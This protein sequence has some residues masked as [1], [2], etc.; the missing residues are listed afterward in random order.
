[1]SISSKNR[2]AIPNK[3]DRFNCVTANKSA[4]KCAACLEFLYL[5]FRRRPCWSSSLV[6]LP[7]KTIVDMPRFRWWETLDENGTTSPGTR[8]AAQ[9]CYRTF[10]SAW[11]LG[12]F[13]AALSL[14]L[15]PQPFRSVRSCSFPRRARSV[16]EQRLVIEPARHSAFSLLLSDKR[17]ADPVTYGLLDVSFTWWCTV[18]HRSN[19]LPTIFKSCNV[20]WILLT[21]SSSRISMTS[22]Y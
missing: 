12:S 4:K 18:V 3:F 15:F 21:S 19:I 2:I 13:S 11:H 8:W 10:S 14:H 1:M 6:A 20:L 9:S 7:L 22:T 5:L 16:R 17:L